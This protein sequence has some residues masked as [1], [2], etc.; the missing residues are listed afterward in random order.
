FDH[1]GAVDAVRDAFHIPVYVHKEEADWLGDATVLV[2]GWF[3]IMT[4]LYNG[5][6]PAA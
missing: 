4:V 1:I 6:P 3:T 2:F 5:Y